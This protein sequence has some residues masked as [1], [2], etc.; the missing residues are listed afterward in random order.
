[1]KPS[2]QGMRKSQFGLSL[3][4]MM[5]GLAVGMLV[6]VAVLGLIVRMSMSRSEVDR[7]GRQIENGRF[8]IHK[9]AEDL[10]HAGYFGE[11]SDLV[12]PDAGVLALDPCS[13]SAAD[14]QALLALPV[15]P[16]HAVATA[17]RP[18]CIPAA[19]FLDGSNVLILR[20][21]SPLVTAPG[22]LDADVMYI[23]TTTA[24]SIVARGNVS[25]PLDTFT[26]TR[27]TALPGAPVPGEI[28]KYIVRIYFLS[29]CSQ[30]GCSSTADGGSPIPTLKMIE[31]D[32]NGG[33]PRFSA[34]VAI[35]EGIERLEFDFGIDTDADGAP[36][37]FTD[38]ASDCTTGDDLANIVTATAY[39][40][41]RDSEPTAGFTDAKS[42][43]LG[44]AGTYT[45]GT[46]AAGFRRHLYSSTLRL[47]NISMR[48]E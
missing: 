13:T 17:S 47:N 15:R 45:P 19:D 10:R 42:Y 25:P 9:L 21:A 24:G 20:F 14:L 34:P 16:H 26:L 39:A 27:Q 40:V 7:T 4:E 36:N 11:F 29:P 41:S 12:V 18:T 44:E 3:I 1:M 38:C 2:I 23:Q 33:T 35:A 28:R 30:T 37:R 5:V 6:V 22:S 46:A 31:L 32:G 48:R 43:E 8:A